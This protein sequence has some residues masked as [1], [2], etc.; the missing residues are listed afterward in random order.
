MQTKLQRGMRSKQIKYDKRVRMAFVAG[1]GV[2][3]EFF[4]RLNRRSNLNWGKKNPA[5]SLRI[6]SADYF[7]NPLN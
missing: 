7:V 6:I 3:P 2:K 5:Y 4:S 1:L